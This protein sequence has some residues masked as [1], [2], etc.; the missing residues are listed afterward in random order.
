MEITD[1]GHL[2]SV[3]RNE[4]AKAHFPLGGQMNNI[5]VMRNPDTLELLGFAP[6]Y[7]S[8][9][10]MFYHVPYEQLLHARTDNITTHSFVEKESRLL[11]YV[12]NRTLVDIDRA[13]MDFSIYEMDTAERHIRIPILQELYEKKRANLKAFQNGKDLWKNR[14]PS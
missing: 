2:G 5:A 4:A 7:D 3:R 6:I 14:R 12:H 10:S 1:E 8:G 11:Q 13:E 9:N